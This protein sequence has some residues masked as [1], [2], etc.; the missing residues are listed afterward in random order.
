MIV[1]GVL[2]GSR[3]ALYYPED[4]VSSN[5]DAWNGMPLTARHPVI[6]GVPVSARD[7]RVF[8]KYHLG[9]VFAANYD[10]RLTAEAWFDV[11]LTN[12]VDKRIIPALNA[13]KQ[14]EISTGLYTKN[15]EAPPGSTYKGRPYTH[16]ARKY[17]PD[18][19]A[20]LVD[21]VGA[22]SLR[23][24]C[25]LNVNTEDY[26]DELEQLWQTWNR[27]WPQSKRDKTPKEDF[28]GP[29]ESFPIQDQADVN[30]AAKLIGHAK[31][32]AAVKARIIAIAKRK[33]LKIP[34]SWQHDSSHNSSGVP[35]VNKEQLIGWLTANCTCWKGPSASTALNAM[36][37]PELQQLKTSAEQ[38][39]TNTSIAN[40]LSTGVVVNGAKV[41]LTN[42]T[43]TAV[44]LTPAPS[45]TPAPTS[46]LNLTPLTTPTANGQATSM[47]DWLAAN[48]SPQEKAVWN[49]MTSDYEA[50][51]QVIINKLTS[52]ITDTAK[53][54]TAQAAYAGFDLDQLK[55]I[56]PAETPAT[57]GGNSPHFALGAG[58]PLVNLNG[59]P[60][61]LTINKVDG[62][63]VQKLTFENPIKKK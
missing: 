10:G 51:R 11:E 59:G 29:N 2:S 38:N 6:D 36:T 28:A 52:H 23:D 39:A 8:N 34:E 44:Q 25:G 49:S 61:N 58:G 50:Q 5:V 60:Q 18:H 47:R 57:N 41:T 42:G 19:L 22:C 14:I 53:K 31:D 12:R 48:G 3:G 63:P 26:V 9:H 15:E 32:P 35:S 56:A 45:A 7:P 13:G 55:A 21:E 30:A 17:R 54:A 20:V 46:V 27:D 16:I 43:L 40:Q 33:G 24:G 37:E 4:E 1:P 62:K